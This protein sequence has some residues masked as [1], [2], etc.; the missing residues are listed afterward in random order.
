MASK[1]PGEIPDFLYGE[2]EDLFPSDEDDQKK[3]VSW[4]QQRFIQAESARKPSEERWLRYYKAFRSY[5]APRKAGQWQSQAWMPI[6]FYVIE[7]ILPRLAAQLPSAV[8]N[9]V[10]PNDVNPAKTMEEVL[11]WAEDK[12]ELYLEQIKAVKSSLLYGTGILKIGYG[13]KKGYNIVDEPVMQETTAEVATGEDV[14]GAPIMQTVQT[15]VEPVLGEDGEP[16]TETVRTE[17][18]TY[19]GPI[20]EAV[21]I[22]NFFPDPIASDIADARYVIHRVYRDRR[23]LE[24]MFKAGTYKRPPEDKWESYL[25]EYASLKRQSEIGYVG[26]SVPDCD[27]TCFP[28]S[29]CGQMISVS[30]FLAKGETE[31]SFVL[32]GTHT[33]TARSPL[34]KSWTTLSPM[35]FGELANSSHLKEF[36]T[37]LTLCGMRGSTT[38][39]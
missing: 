27:V 34:L 3:A 19:Q 33:R 28:C 37:R 23:H 17:Y 36:R 4:L 18:F 29:S 32:R 30:L 1:L 22:E 24:K 8:V 35:S 5:V 26:D 2:D 12:S 14:D 7:T 31:S 6:S 11:H 21:D 25:T 39:S 10:G 9:P 16:K 13:E 20:A 15:G 38:L